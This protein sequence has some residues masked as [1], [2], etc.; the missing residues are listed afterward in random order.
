L[1]AVLITVS[2]CIETAVRVFMQ[3][4]VVMSYVNAAH[5]FSS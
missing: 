2:G 3:T 1:R 4:K 5:F